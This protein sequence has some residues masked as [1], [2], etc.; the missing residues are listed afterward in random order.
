MALT[1]IT[2]YIEVIEKFINDFAASFQEKRWVKILVTVGVIAAIFFNPAA[3]DY[4]LTLLSFRKPEWYSYLIWGIITGLFFIIAFFYALLTKE[5]KTI[6]STP[7][8][9]I[10]KGLLP[11]TNTQEDSEWFAKLQRGHILQDALTFC[12]QGDYPFGILSGE[13]GTG[14]TSFL[15]AGLLPN[16]EKLNYRPIYVK[17]RDAP[18]L[19]SIQQSFSEFVN[20]NSSNHSQKLSEIITQAKDSDSRSIILILDQFE[21]FFVH[22]KS[23]L[24]RSQFI[25]QFTEWYKSKH[26]QQIKIL[27][28]IRGDYLNRMNEF[29]K[30]MKYTLTPYNNLSLE[31]FE[32]FEAANVIK[33]IADEVK[34]ELDD[35][36]IKELTTHEIADREDG[37]ISPIDIQILSR[38]I[39][40]QKNLEERA[41]N[42][43]A[44][45]KLGGVEGLLER[46]LNTTLKSLITDSRRQ[47]T[48]KVMLAMT[49]GNL[50]TGALSLKGLKEKLD[51]VISDADIE[52]SVFWLSR[53]EIRLITP[54][55]EKNNIVYELAHERIIP[56]LRRL[57]SK[58]ITEIEQTEQML[59]RRVNEWLG[60]NR[61]RRYLLTLKEWYLIR[62]NRTSIKIGSQK[63]QKES[64]ISLS[65]N[66]FIK[67]GVVSAMSVLLMFIAYSGY[68]KYKQHQEEY[69][70]WYE[71]QPET[72][73]L[74]AQERII[75][76]LDRNKDD[77][78]LLN[79]LYLLAALD[80]EKKVDFTEDL[81]KKLSQVIFTRKDASDF[82]EV[83]GI[84][85]T[86]KEFSKINIGFDR[87]NMLWQKIG[88]SENIGI[89]NKLKLLSALIKISEDNSNIEEALK[90]IEITWRETEKAE[91]L[92]IEEKISMLFELAYKCHN[93][94]KNDEALKYIEIA[95]RNG[96][97]MNADLKPSLFFALEEVLDKLPKTEKV[98]EVLSKIR[99]DRLNKGIQDLTTETGSGSGFGEGN[100]SGSGRGRSDS[101]NFHLNKSLTKMIESSKNLSNPLE[102]IRVLNKVLDKIE[103]GYG[104]NKDEVVRPLIEEYTKLPHLNALE[105]IEKVSQRFTEYSPIEKIEILT[106]FI[107][108]FSKLSDTDKAT[109]GLNKVWD[110]ANEKCKCTNNIS[111]LL[112]F[113]QNHK[114]LPRTEKLVQGSE[115]VR[116][117]INDIQ[118]SIDKFFD[119]KMKSDEL[120]YNFNSTY[121]IELAELHIYTSNNVN[122]MKSLGQAR[123]LAGLTNNSTEKSDSLV[124]ISNLYAK[125]KNWEESLNTAQLVVNEPDT[126]LALSKILIIWYDE[127]ND[128]KNIDILEKLTEKNLTRF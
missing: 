106:L 108:S 4:G 93:L 86:Y 114:N 80:S 118:E 39:D 48:I 56:P 30:E 9:S 51:G 83:Q 111:L 15:Q 47:T 71:K 101:G 38:M 79:V 96:E 54:I 69:L 10:I 74:R 113:E 127:K 43:K 16:L 82:R 125:L 64:F 3:V 58:E 75:E 55:R 6:Y 68:I 95:W 120:P 66:H 19:E 60:N 59:D 20:G 26:S 103:K 84:I 110:I 63:E 27:I 94:A 12:R 107:N 57:A 81:W 45:Q 90:Y 18:P 117:K 112:S 14:K 41:F 50:R 61:A 23:K 2:N 78:T 119:N 123:E 21:Q 17:F 52:E 87:L 100:G 32:P 37:T 104:V 42:R 40:G 28:S 98:A 44:F 70:Q 88:N 128:T 53:S 31:K 35:N 92:N 102:K 1:D 7:T 85:E 73:I 67:K 65:R 105:S 97:N 34:I 76:L 89:K 116:Q 29:Q 8:V 77:Q 62:R 124:K 33:V 121:L 25:Q 36:F 109:D 99:Q 11:Y 13:S 22:N 49:D 115:K 91:T 122:G 72:R 24:Q 126:I 46:F 5:S